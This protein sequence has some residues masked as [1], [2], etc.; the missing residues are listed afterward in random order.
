MTPETAVDQKTIDVSKLPST[1]LDYDEPLWWGNLLLL[2]IET[3]MFG[4]LI[5]VYFNVSMNLSPFPPPQIDRFPV[6][7]NPVPELLIPTINLVVLLVSLIPAIYLD[8]AARRKDLGAVK[9][10][11]ILTIT[12][13][14]VVIVLRFYE[15]NSLIFRWDENAYGSIIWTI[16]GT[17][18]L[19]L[20]IMASEDAFL[21]VWT[22]KKGLDDKHALDLTVMAVY[23]YWVVGIWV[24]LYA[25]V[26]WAPRLL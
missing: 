11:L 1:L 4:I 6:N 18:L 23:W 10:G 9:L 12:F 26:Y 22:F 7:Y 8:R 13:N 16:L 15:F 17:H 5:A 21:M 14:I 20:F 19:H 2:F 25:L 3:T 24:L